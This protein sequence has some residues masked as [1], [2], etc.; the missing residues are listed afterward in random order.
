[1]KH[2]TAGL[3][4]HDCGSIGLKSAVSRRRG[5]DLKSAR[6]VVQVKDRAAP[7]FG[8]HAHGLLEC[9]AAVAICAEYIARSAAGVYPHQYGARRRSWRQARAQADT[10]IIQRRRAVP[11]RKIRTQV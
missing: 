5:L 1:M 9:F 4:L 2:Q 10:G 11:A 6:G 8:D 7:L 3:S